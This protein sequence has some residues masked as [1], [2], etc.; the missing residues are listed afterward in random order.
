MSHLFCL[1]ESLALW[2]CQLT[3][4]LRLMLQRREFQR[5]MAA[6]NFL[7]D[8]SREIDRTLAATNAQCY[9]RTAAV[10]CALR[11]GLPTGTHAAI[12]QARW[13]C[14]QT[15]RP[16][17]HLHWRRPWPRCGSDRVRTV[18][19]NLEHLLSHAKGVDRSLISPSHGGIVQRT[20]AL[21]GHHTRLPT[22]LEVDFA[23]RQLL[24]QPLY[25]VFGH[26]HAIERQLL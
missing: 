13:G 16:R 7:G 24:A 22:N 15:S 10:R 5:R 9:L 11:P 23:I 25:A 2:A 14:F 26:V 12:R 4:W 18:Q 6:P 21:E 3:Q 20:K 1:F 8:D 17:H 19:M